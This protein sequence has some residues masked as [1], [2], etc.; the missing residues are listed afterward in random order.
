[1]TEKTTR[2]SLN[3]RYL[4]EKGS[5]TQELIADLLKCSRYAI[6]RYE[7]GNRQPDYATLRRLATIYKTTVEDLLNE[8][9]SGLF[10]RSATTDKENTE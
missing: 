1:M 4:R 5:Y 2:L 8:D 3:L 6:C 10:S 9:L 7:K